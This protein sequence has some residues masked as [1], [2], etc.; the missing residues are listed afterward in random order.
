MTAEKRGRGRPPLDPEG[1]VDTHLRLTRAQAA[2]AERVARALG[3]VEQ[4][5]PRDERPVIAA[6]IRRMLDAY[7]EPGAS[8]SCPPGR[9]TCR[10]HG[11]S[12]QSENSI[13]RVLTSQI[14]ASSIAFVAAQWG[15]RQRSD[16]MTETRRTEEWMA[17]VRDAGLARL[18]EGRADE[19]EMASV[20][21][22]PE[23]SGSIDGPG[24]APLPVRAFQAADR[25]R[26]DVM[27]MML[28]RSRGAIGYREEARATLEALRRL[29]DH[30]DIEHGA[31]R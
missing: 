19:A 12:A 1:T 15:A 10:P 30:D 29:L 8:G 9:I 27:R 11:P 18:S 3:L 21:S 2:K 23:I 25:L 28:C 20:V 4:D 24:I 17:R 14:P 7:P 26:D 16:E 22:S 6:A 13:G 5:G 31:T